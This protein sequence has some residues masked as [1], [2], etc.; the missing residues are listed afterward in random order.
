MAEPDVA[1][2]PADVEDSDLEHEDR[3][4]DRVLESI[5][6]D[7][8]PDDVDPLGIAYGLWLRLTSLLLFCGF[9]SQELIT[10][11]REEDLMD[12]EPKGNA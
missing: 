10:D 6:P 9:S 11:V 2:D 8:L 3:I 1:R 4:I 7:E 12:A 5:A